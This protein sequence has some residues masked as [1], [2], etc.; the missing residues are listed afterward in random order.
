MQKGDQHLGP[1]SVVDEWLDGLEQDPE[2][3]RGVDEHNL[4]MNWVSLGEGG[5]V[6]SQA[7]RAFK[8]MLA[9]GRGHFTMSRGGRSDDIPGLPSQA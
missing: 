9:K 3:Q 5:T 4:S 2:Y 6:V 7:M 1:C 8:P